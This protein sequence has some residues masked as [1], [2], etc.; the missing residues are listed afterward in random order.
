MVLPYHFDTYHDI[1]NY[2]AILVYYIPILTSS[3]LM[4]LFE[5]SYF[6]LGSVLSSNNS[7]IVFLP[8]SYVCHLSVV[9]V[10][11]LIGPPAN[12]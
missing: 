5:S 7:L 9:L 8:Q 11:L 1:L 3:I 4:T 12:R 2:Y 10:Y 6:P